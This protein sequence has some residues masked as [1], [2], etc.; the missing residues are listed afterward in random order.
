MHTTRFD[1]GW[2]I[3]N[4]DWSGDAR[5][6]WDDGKNMVAVPGPVLKAIAGSIIAEAVESAAPHI[7]AAILR[8]IE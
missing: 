5:I 6:H 1:G 4:G 3:H 8:E 2:V 7:A